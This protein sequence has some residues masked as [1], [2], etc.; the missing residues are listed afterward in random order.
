M[1]DDPEAR[2]PACLRLLVTP[3]VKGGCRP[4]V[5]F[6]E[7]P[8]L[9]VCKRNLVTGCVFYV[10]QWV[11]IGLGSFETVR[12]ENI[13]VS[14][15]EENIFIWCF[16]LAIVELAMDLEIE[17]YRWV[18]Y[19]YID[20]PISSLDENNAVMVAHHL[21]Q[22]LAASP[23]QVKAVVSTHHVLFFNVLCNELKKSR[24]YFLTRDASGGFL[25][26]DRPSH[27]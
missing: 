11:N 13:K 5:Y 12:E 22:M 25:L 21:A 6:G 4:K 10:C 14:R 8:R 27:H 20:D 18:K 23:Q 9:V 16:F 3:S 7:V 1:R 17:A 15:G 19:I 24:K 26:A 2:R